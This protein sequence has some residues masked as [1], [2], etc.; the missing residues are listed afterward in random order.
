[1]K[2]CVE[3][4][5]FNIIEQKYEEVLT[6]LARDLFA[7][8]LNTFSQCLIEKSIEQYREHPYVIVNT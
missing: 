5:I 8:I 4:F 1:M 6:L 7:N 2:Y 3:H